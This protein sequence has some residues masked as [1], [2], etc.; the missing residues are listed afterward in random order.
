M[1]K[2]LALQ[3]P[4][5]LLFRLELQAREQGVSLEALCLSLLSGSKLE[6]TLVEPD[7]YRVLNHETMRIELRKVIESDLPSAEKK[8]RVNNLEFYISKRYIR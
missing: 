2:E 5:S 7:F 8:K 4:D 1:Y 6:E 3:I